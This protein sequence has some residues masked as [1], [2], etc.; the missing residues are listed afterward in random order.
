M[1]NLIL[2]LSMLIFVSCGSFLRKPQILDGPGMV[3][4]PDHADSISFGLTPESD[5]VRQRTAEIYEAVEKEYA[6]F[7]YGSRES[8]LDERFCSKAWRDAVKSV[9]EK[10]EQTEDICL[11]YDYWVMGQDVSDF[12][13]D[14]INVDQFYMEEGSARMSLKVHNCGTTTPV[15]IILVNE[16][17]QW[18]IDNFIDTKNNFDWRQSMEKYLKE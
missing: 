9:R 10:E 8:D 7:R 1:R 11:D 4:E 16:G 17:G 13:V 2:F 18:L 5:V 12:H 15:V 3:H 14:S 6:T